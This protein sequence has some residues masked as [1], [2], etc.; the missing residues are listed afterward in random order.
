MYTFFRNRFLVN[1]N[2]T[3]LGGHHRF[4]TSPT[5]IYEYATYKS[6]DIEYKPRKKET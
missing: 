1:W 3:K 4:S 6:L 5:H 2:I